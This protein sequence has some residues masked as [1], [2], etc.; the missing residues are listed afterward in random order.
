MVSRPDVSF[1][2]SVRLAW[3]LVA[4][5]AVALVGCATPRGADGPGMEVSNWP[6]PRA[7]DPVE[8][9]HQKPVETVTHYTSI[10]PGKGFEH[11]DKVAAATDLVSAQRYQEADALLDEVLDAFE[12]LMTREAILYVSVASQEEL[13]LFKREFA[14][15][16]DVVWLDW[17]FRE[18]LL[19][20]AFL[21]AGHRRFEDSLEILRVEAAFAPF[22]AAVHCERGYVLNQM[23]RPNEGLDAYRFALELAMRF[24]SSRPD[25]PVAWR[26]IGYSLIE[27]DDLEGAEKAYQESLRLQPD[28]P[29]AKQ[30]LEYIQKLR[31]RQGP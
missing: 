13:D 16:R 19:V 5:L 24:E 14:E 12:Q 3:A 1:H 26:G 9:A 20:K 15:G 23:Q 31:Q 18:A 27:L 21:A 11:R 25:M 4:L 28:N 29:L 2:G 10:E 17:A 8:V 30:E 6:Q 7:D 22:T